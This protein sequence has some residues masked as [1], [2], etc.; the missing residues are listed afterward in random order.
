V[1]FAAGTAA[2]RTISTRALARSSCPLP[3]PELTCDWY[4]CSSFVRFRC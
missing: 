4:S 2:C 3:N 1:S